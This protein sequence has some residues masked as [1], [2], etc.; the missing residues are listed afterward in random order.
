[1]PTLSSLP[2]TLRDQRLCKGGLDATE[3]L[4]KQ[5]ILMFSFCIPFS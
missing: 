3:E 5:K 1:M 4:D 2:H